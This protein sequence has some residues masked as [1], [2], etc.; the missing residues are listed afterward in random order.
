MKILFVGST[1]IG[2]TS[3]MRLQVLRD[4]GHDVW[5][6]DSAG[7]WGKVGAVSRRAQQAA[8]AG[9][10]ISELN[11]EVAKAARQFGPDLLWAEKQE[12][13]RADM[14]ED[15]AR[16]GARL[17]HFTPDP[18]FTLTWKQ[19]R[20][21]REAMQ[22]Y[23]LLLT[24]KRYELAEYAKLPGR[25]IYMPLGFA[26]AVHRPLV[27]GTRGGYR[28][29][30]SDV[31]FLGGWEPRREEALSRIAGDDRLRLR[32][33]G[34][35]WDHLEDG[36]STPRRYLA[37]RRN[38]GGR[39]FS[40]TRNGRLAEAVAGG[41][42]YGDDYAYALSAAR[43]GLGFLREICPDQHTTR[44]FEIPACGSLLLADRTG[45]HEELF[46]E[47]TEAEFF[48]SVD[49]MLDKLDFYH[50]NEDA[51]A[52]VAR[53]GFERCH[54]SGYSYRERLSTAMREISGPA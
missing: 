29:F 36:R 14:L 12:Y 48:G 13:L 46:E 54:R 35:G 43:I 42:V 21:S 15:I 4:L 34:Y 33:W 31:S 1:G 49:E 45:E 16:T 22:V 32:V 39:R 52:R 7:R 11:D 3:Q 37:M 17:L 8:C 25:V 28:H 40:I 41:E 24:S 6:V 10:V 9:P 18:Y 2:Q 27:P 30:A 44:T 23:H 26:E 47:G 53:A 50:R 5:P 38:A 20:L 51:R 19:T